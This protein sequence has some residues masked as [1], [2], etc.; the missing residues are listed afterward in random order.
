MISID[1][2]QRLLLNIS[3]RL[4]QKITVYAIG[5]TAMM[6]H[7]FKDSTLDIDLV[8]ESEKDRTIFKKA[9][10]SIGYQ[11]MDAIQIYGFKSNRPQMLTLGDERFDLFVS[12]V[13]NFQFSDDMQKRSQQTHLYTDS[14]LVRISDPHDI[15]LMKCATDRAKDKDDAKK[16]LESTNINWEVIISE[17]KNQIRLGEEMAAFELG[18][19]LEEL[20][21]MKVKI[22][23]QTLDELFKIVQEQSKQKLKTRKRK[24]K[25]D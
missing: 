20:K 17:A 3:R 1:K 22:P 6:F 13:I 2:Q 14:L 11:E 18:C 25:K 8:F 21:K 5:G 24:T 4:K 10:K 12:R 16:I 7:G 9:A 19:F 23:Q 15:I